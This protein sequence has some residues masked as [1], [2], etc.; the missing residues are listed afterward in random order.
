MNSR[1][2][3]SF[4]CCIA[5]STV[6]V[7]FRVN[8]YGFF[9]LP[10]ESTILDGGGSLDY[11]RVSECS[12]GV[13]AIERRRSDSCGNHLPPGSRPHHSISYLSYLHCH[14]LILS[15]V[16]EMDETPSVSSPIARL[17]IQ[18]MRT[19]ER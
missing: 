5:L 12:T 19:H 3:S 10:K 9:P 15:S 4:C 1:H 7:S 2:D 14:T 13:H 16:M 11:G 8:Y 17:S 18:R 6:R